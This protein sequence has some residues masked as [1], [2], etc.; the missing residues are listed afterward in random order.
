MVKKLESSESEF[1]LKQDT[2]RI[3]VIPEATDEGS[4]CKQE[5]EESKLIVKAHEAIKII[6]EACSWEEERS[7]QRVPPSR[8]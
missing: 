2:D 1:T 3:K 4:S 8:N 6:P 7:T 5:I